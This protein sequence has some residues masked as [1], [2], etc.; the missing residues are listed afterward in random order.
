MG[1]FS[2]LF[3]EADAAFNGAYKEA[4]EKLAGLSKEDVDSV[5]PDTEDSRVYLVLIKVVERASKENSSKA[6][7]IEDIKE[8]GDVA[9][10][11]AIKVPQLAILF[12]N[13]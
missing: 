10:K 9:V 7:L 4:L 2:K 1:R 12:E 11:I 3:A 6:Q 8:L 5:T 13:E